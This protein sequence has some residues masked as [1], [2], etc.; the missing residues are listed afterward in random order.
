MC[1]IASNVLTCGLKVI[2]EESLLV[3]RK[4]ENVPAGTVL[5]LIPVVDHLF[6]DRDCCQ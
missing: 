1:F 5:F 4:I 3:V 2:D 6:F